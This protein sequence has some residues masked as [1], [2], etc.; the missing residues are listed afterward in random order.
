M[1]SSTHSKPDTEN[2]DVLTIYYGI[3]DALRELGDD[4]HD[5][6]D[7]PGLDTPHVT[8]GLWDASRALTSLFE[9]LATAET[10]RDDFEASQAKLLKENDDLQVA[11]DAAQIRLE[12]T[13]PRYEERVRELEEQYEALSLEREDWNEHANEEITEH[14][15]HAARLEE[16][17]EAAREALRQIVDASTRRHFE[18]KQGQSGPWV[19]LPVVDMG[20]IARKALDFNPAP[21]TSAP[22][23]AK[24]PSA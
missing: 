5:A 3:H 6:G 21:N 23:P 22:S 14:K 9:Q 17:L 4:L 12:D 11:N 20:E 1:T 7:G 10:E 15:L 2:V 8:S 13:I 16:Q 24:E 19:V 18:F